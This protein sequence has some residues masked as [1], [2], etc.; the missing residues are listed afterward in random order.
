MKVTWLITTLVFLLDYVIKNYLRL[1]FSFQSLPVIK[2]IFHITIVFNEGA[3]FGM[4]QGK[5]PLLIVIG[6]IFLSI[7]YLILKSEKNKSLLFFV[8][9]GMIFGG[10]ISNLYDRIVLGFVVDYLDF[11]IWPVFNLSD[12]CISVG[13]GLLILQSFH[14][15]KKNPN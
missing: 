8:A 5:T 13:A 3:A 11:R 1:N 2:N 12:T 15:H 4:L 10:A 6:I 14:K 7:F 9:S